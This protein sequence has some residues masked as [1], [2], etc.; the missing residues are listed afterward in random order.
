MSKFI[1][2]KGVKIPP[3]WEDVPPGILVKTVD[4]GETFIY[5]G[6]S[7]N[8]YAQVQNM[9]GTR[10]E[11]NYQQLV[12]VKPWFPQ[13]SETVAVWNGKGDI[14]KILRYNG[15]IS[16]PPELRPRYATIAGAYIYCAR[17][18]QEWFDSGC[19]LEVDWWVKY[20]EQAIK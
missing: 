19:P 3:A 2:H 9:S 20:G 13:V 8:G 5:C 4:S 14:V 6:V 15:Y 18:T 10:L 16:G 17:L 12:I 7:H 11:F 1:K